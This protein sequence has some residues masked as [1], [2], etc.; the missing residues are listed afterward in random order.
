M[1][2]QFKTLYNEII[3]PI[4]HRELIVRLTLLLSNL[5][6]LNSIKYQNSKYTQVQH[7]II[8]QGISSLKNLRENEPELTKL[9]LYSLNLENFLNT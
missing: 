7:Q 1:D 6:S 5:P 2:Q 4:P 9:A 8:E 3:F